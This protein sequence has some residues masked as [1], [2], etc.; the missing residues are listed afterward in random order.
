MG[1]DSSDK[2]LQ[3]LRRAQAKRVMPLIGSLLDAWEGCPNDVR[4]DIE[5]FVPSLYAQLQN[6][7]KAVEEDGDGR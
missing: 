1:A 7:A 6:I 4:S 3:S 5:C 2:Y